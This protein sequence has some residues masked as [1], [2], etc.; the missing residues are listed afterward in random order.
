[1]MVVLTAILVT[2][3]RKL[4]QPVY[5]ISISAF[6]ILSAAILYSPYMPELVKVKLDYVSKPHK[7]PSFQIRIQDLKQAL[8]NENF[9][10][11]EKLFGEGFGT[12]SVIHRDIPWRQDVT[13]AFQFQEIDNGFYYLYHRGGWT[14]L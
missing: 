6:L 1:I 13:I 10:T 9:N 4:L 5:I 14:L 2:N 7:Y 3:F 8:S 12:R 11:I